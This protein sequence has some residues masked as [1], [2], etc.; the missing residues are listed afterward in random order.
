MNFFSRWKDGGNQNKIHVPNYEGTR[1]RYIGKS[2]EKIGETPSRVMEKANQIVMYVIFTCFWIFTGRHRS[3][4][5]AV[6]VH[7]AV[8]EFTLRFSD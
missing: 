5:V 3:A 1:Q 6:V 4:S 8:V 7:S 2:N